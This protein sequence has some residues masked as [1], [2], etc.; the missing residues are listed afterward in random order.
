MV[1]V[2]VPLFFMNVVL[3]LICS[4][5]KTSDLQ[6]NYSKNK[7]MSEFHTLKQSV[8]ICF[9]YTAIHKILYYTIIRFTFLH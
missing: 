1:T 5:P 2:K 9:G 7:F 4:H 3:L 8:Q 6:H